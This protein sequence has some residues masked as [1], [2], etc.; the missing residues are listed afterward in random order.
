MTNSNR[1]NKKSAKES[2]YAGAV[3]G[4]VSRAMVQPLDVLKI[5]LQVVLKTK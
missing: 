4:F 1:S 5:R 3:S 2:A